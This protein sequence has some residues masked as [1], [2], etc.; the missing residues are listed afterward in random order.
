[1]RLTLAAEGNPVA[2]RFLFGGDAEVAVWERIRDK[3]ADADLNYDVLMAPHHCSWHSLSWDSWSQFRDKAK[4]SE[5][6]RSALAQ[7]AAGAIIVSSSNSIVDDDRD[8]PCI[9]AKRE[10]EAILK[11]VV[12]PFRCIADE[13]GNDPLEINV[14][15]F[16]VKP[17]RIVAGLAGG[18]ATGIGG[19]ALAHG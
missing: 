17:S 16:G 4:V 18:L 13:P 1:L 19:E 9:R 15:Y 5:K 7:A 6:A 14:G 8:P 2:G 11:P 12:G 3:Y 10:Y